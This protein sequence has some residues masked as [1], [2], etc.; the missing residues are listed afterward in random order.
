MPFANIFHH[1]ASEY[2]AFVDEVND[3]LL[4]VSPSK[5]ILMGHFNAHIGTD[6]ET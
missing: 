2:H 3:A 1:A 5:S 6:T 4:R